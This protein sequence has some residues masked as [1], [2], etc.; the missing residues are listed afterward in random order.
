LFLWL[1]IGGKDATAAERSP[2]AVASG[3]RGAAKSVR[4]RRRLVATDRQ[5]V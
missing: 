5:L 4:D 3:G 1:S 2:D